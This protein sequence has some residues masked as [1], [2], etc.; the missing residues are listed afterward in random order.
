M[1]TTR[2]ALL[3]LLVLPGLVMG[4][5]LSEVAKREKERRE[6]NKKQGKTVHV[7]SEDDL[8]PDGRPESGDG[9]EGDGE[10]T[11]TQRSSSRD[12]G[13]EL[14]GIEE[15][16]DLPDSIPPDAPLDQKL[17][18]FEMMKRA[19]ERQVAEIDKSIAENK[20]RL[21]ELQ[22]EIGATSAS[23]GAGLPV[24]P[25]TG[26]GVANKPMTGQE[27]AGLVA[28]QNRLQQINQQLEARKG[29]LK[30]ALQEK[31]RVAGIPPGYLRF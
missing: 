25:Q 30:A 9:E 21:R 4:Q 20:D 12:R 1:R 6:K 24:A 3:L 28:E 26:T 17:K 5:S 29:Q 13:L 8:Y 19:Y 22:A 27:S 10:G 18:L 7:I 16:E 23:G 11:T 2:L 15:G 14:E 31:G